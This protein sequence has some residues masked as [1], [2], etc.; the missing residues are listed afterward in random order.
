MR[1]KTGPYRRRR[2]KAI[3]ELASGYRMSK[4][5]LHKASSDAVLHAGEYAYMGRKRR[6]RDFRQLWITRINAALTNQPLSYSRFI[7]SLKKENIQLDRKILA[8][9]ATMDPQIFQALV[10]KVTNR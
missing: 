2:H 5:R 1:V 7:N 8:D 10:E 3:R 9:L 4:H 6:K